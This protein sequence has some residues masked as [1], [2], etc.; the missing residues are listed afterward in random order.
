M[1][2]DEISELRDRVAEGWLE[3]ETLSAEVNRLRSGTSDLNASL[4]A[5]VARLRA[6]LGECR[7]RGSSAGKS[8]D[9]YRKRAEAAEARLDAMAPQLVKSEEQK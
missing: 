7:Q 3:I 2:R 9:Y 5:E 1:S 6:Q 4:V 8:A